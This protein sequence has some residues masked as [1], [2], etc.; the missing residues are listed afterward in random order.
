MLTQPIPFF[1]CQPQTFFEENGREEEKKTTYLGEFY[2]NLINKNKKEKKTDRPSPICFSL[3]PTHVTVHK[4]WV[5]CCFFILFGPAR[6]QCNAA[7]SGDILW[8]NV[9]GILF[10]KNPF[11][12]FFSALKNSLVMSQF[13]MVMSPMSWTMSGSSPLLVTINFPSSQPQYNG[14]FKEKTGSSA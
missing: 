12:F 7:A 4:V 9:L 2:P 3:P 5:W 6:Q 13:W 1:L 10:L 8:M 11:L 14:V